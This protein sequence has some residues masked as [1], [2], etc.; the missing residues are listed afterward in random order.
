ML[1]SKSGGRVLSCGSRDFRSCC[2]CS[3]K[4]ITGLQRSAVV[5]RNI[6]TRRFFPA[7]TSVSVLVLP[8]SRQEATMKPLDLWRWEGRVKGSTYLSVGIVAFA[9]KMLLDFSI[10]TFGFHRFWTPFFYL[11]PFGTFFY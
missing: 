1:R 7:E 6:A 2:A 3:K 4:A 9:I 10:S 11:R 5:L 8:G